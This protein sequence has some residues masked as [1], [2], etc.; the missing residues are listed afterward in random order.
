MPKRTMTEDSVFEA[1]DMWAADFREALMD[2]KTYPL[3]HIQ[4]HEDACVL[5]RQL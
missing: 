5:Q 4:F 3:R 1:I 2:K